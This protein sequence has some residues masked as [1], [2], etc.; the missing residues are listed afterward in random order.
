[1]MRNVTKSWWIESGEMSRKMLPINDNLTSGK[2]GQVALEVESDC[3]IEAAANLL[4]AV[5]Q[6]ARSL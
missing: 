3:A 4:K 5:S 1:M 6:A 2:V